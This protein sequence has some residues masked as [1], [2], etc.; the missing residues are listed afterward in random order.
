VQQ[1]RSPTKQSCCHESGWL[2]LYDKFTQNWYVL[3]KAFRT[4]ANVSYKGL[5][6]DKEGLKAARTR[7][8][9]MY[10]TGA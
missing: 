3:A 2:L 10:A 9:G 5:D 6:I 7:H 4:Y 8:K 1:I